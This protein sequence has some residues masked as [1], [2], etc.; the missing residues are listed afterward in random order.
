VDVDA[1]DGSL[2]RIVGDLFTVDGQGV[3]F[4]PLSDTSG[5]LGGTLASGETLLATFQ[6]DSATESGTIHLLSSNDMQARKDFRTIG[7]PAN[8]ADPATGLGAV[9]YLYSIQQTEVSNTEYAEFLSGSALTDP[10]DLYDSR[11][12]SD[13]RGGILRTG[14]DGNFRYE[15]ISGRA[16]LP[17]VFVSLF[18]AMRYANWLHNGR[19]SGTGDAGTEDGSYQFVDGVLQ[20][21]RQPKAT[22]A[23]PTRDEWYKAA[24]YDPATKSYFA[25]PTA[26]DTEPASQL[27]TRDLGNGAN[28]GDALQDDSEPLTEAGAYAFSASSYGTLDQ[29]GNVLEWNE[30]SLDLMGGHWGTPASSTDRQATPVSIAGQGDQENFLGF[31]IPEPSASLLAMAAMATLASLRGRRRS[32]R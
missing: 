9:A 5:E 30:D 12:G 20:G 6:Q 27:P 4:G 13:P 23:V 17:V 29:A 28:A 24:Y 26:S 32:A 1:L 14:A 2:I 11:M 3:P 15:T 19:P 8:A 21:G 10:H 31:R 7:D 25:F 16:N 22:F 18:D